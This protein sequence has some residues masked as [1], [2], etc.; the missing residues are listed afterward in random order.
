MRLALDD[1][2]TGYSSFTYLRRLPVDEIKIDRAFVAGMNDHASDRAIVRGTIALGHELDLDVV[3]EG[4]E[5]PAQDE[6]LAALGC[7]TAQGY[8]YLRPTS[9]EDV[10]PFLPSRAAARSRRR[11]AVAR[12]KGE[13]AAPPNAREAHIAGA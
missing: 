5:L 1:F 8:L 4:V 7:D 9:P 12:R 13:P 11:H 2:G 6:A 3:A 10:E